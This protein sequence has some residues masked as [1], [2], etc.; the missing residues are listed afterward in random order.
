MLEADIDLLKKNISVDITSIGSKELIGYC[1]VCNRK[2]STRVGDDTI[3]T[4]G[5]GDFFT[6]LGKKDSMYQKRWQKTF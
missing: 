5:L 1:S 3:K 2:K 6:N 4:E